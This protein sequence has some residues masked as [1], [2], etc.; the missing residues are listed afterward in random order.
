[1][2]YHLKPKQGAVLTIESS[3]FAKALVSVQRTQ[4]NI[5]VMDEV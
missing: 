5:G 1:M 2:I 3:L 4:P